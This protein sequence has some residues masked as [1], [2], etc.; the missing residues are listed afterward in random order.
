MRPIQLFQ[1][2]AT[3]AHW[4]SVRQDV[5]A[6]N[7]ANVNT[8]GYKAMDVEP[9]SS[10][11][12]RMNEGNQTMAADSAMHLVS[13]DPNDA[14]KTEPVRDGVTIKPSG[15]SVDLPQELIKQGDIRSQFELNTG[16]VKSFHQM[17]MMTV[18]S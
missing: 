11:L 1:L 3:Q 15:N 8:P 6:G 13:D 16:L 5:V 2:A 10:L 12:D 18:K 14:V 9:F 17:M 4:L 7:V